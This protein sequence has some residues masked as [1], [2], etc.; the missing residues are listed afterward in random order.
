M[1]NALFKGTFG[2]DFGYRIVRVKDLSSAQRIN[3]TSNKPNYTY[4]GGSYI[5][6]FKKKED[7]NITKKELYNENR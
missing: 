6:F 1:L 4:I 3:F 2:M 7:M 5:Y